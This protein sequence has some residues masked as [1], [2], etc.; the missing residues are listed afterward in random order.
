MRAHNFGAGP[1]TLPLDVLEEAKEEFLD[2]AGTGM[3]ILEMSHRSSE[4]EAVHNEA[5][6]LARRVGEAPDEFEVLFVQGGATLQFAMVALNLLQPEEK[7]A[8][9][10]SGS[11]G[12]RALQDAQPHGEVYAA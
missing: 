12:A 6:E 4:Y 1:C 8:Y 7:G 11:W 3:S 2:F 5:L 10:V 9:V